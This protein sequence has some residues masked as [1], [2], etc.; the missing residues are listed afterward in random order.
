MIVVASV[1]LMLMCCVMVSVRMMQF[2][3]EQRRGTWKT[4]VPRTIMGSSGRGNVRGS[5][6]V[7]VG[8]SVSP[9]PHSHTPDDLG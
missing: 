6:F 5:Y 7:K 4:A 2:V 3:R 9:W 8:E 1:L